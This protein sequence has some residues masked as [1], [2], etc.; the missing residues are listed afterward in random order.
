MPLHPQVQ[1]LLDQAAAAGA[2]PLRALTVQEARAGM[3]SMIPVKGDGP[4]VG[5]VVDRAIQGPGGEIP[6]RI[7]WPEGVEP[8]PVVVWLHGG[9]W[10]LG[11]LDTADS[12]CRNLTVKSGAIV[13][14]VDYRLAPENPYPAAVDDAY[15]AVSWAAANAQE[16][17]G[18]VGRVAVG[19]DSAGGNLA[20]VTA[21]QAKRDGG[22]ALCYQLLV[23]PVTD[24]KMSY[25]SYQEN[26]TGYQLTADTM[27]FFY[28]LY[29][30]DR[31]PAD[32]LVSPLYASAEDIAKLPPA[33]VIT[34][35]YDPLRDEG[36]A[37]A[38]RLEQAG[39]TVKLTRYDGQIHGFFGLDAFIDAGKTALDEAAAA[40]RAAF[41]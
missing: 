36:E 22:P 10:V 26:G 27:Q 19:G 41:G 40:L 7:Y 3:R 28:E 13:M 34:A 32:P 15:A 24:G 18:D 16:I 17:G 23:Y 12:T 25:P 11:D 4:N 37:Y 9:G 29:L 14:S 2:P 39:V 20:T 21:L 8:F 30:G 31:D 5:R 38:R 35:E 6:V 1:A 33:L